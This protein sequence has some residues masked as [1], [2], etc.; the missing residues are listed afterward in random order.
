MVED[1]A[2]KYP[3]TPLPHSVRGRRYGT[4]GML[5][6]NLRPLALAANAQQF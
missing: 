5:L 4:E 3:E 1:R 2:V 6:H